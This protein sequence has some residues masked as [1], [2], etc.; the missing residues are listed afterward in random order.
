MYSIVLPTGEL[1]AKI[2]NK[3]H[4]YRMGRKFGD[5]MVLSPTG[6]IVYQF[7]KEDRDKETIVELLE[8]GYSFEMGRLCVSAI[9]RGSIVQYQVY[10]DHYKMKFN[11]LY[12]SPEQAANKF[13]ELKRKIS[14]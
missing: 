10:S 4:A 8:D 13:M 3:V 5:C 14:Q 1:I 9:K 7:S 12:K 11:E 2:Q 6:G